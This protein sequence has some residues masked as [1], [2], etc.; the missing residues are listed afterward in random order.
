MSVMI[1]LVRSAIQ[2]SKPKHPVSLLRLGSF[3]KPYKQLKVSNKCFTRTS[4]HS[5]PMDKN[6]RATRSCFHH[7]SLVFGYLGETTV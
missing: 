4:K 3:E 6:T 7:Y 2:I 1:C 5:N